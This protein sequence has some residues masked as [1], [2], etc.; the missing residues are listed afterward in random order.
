MTS[1][2]SVDLRMGTVELALRFVHI[3]RS[4]NLKSYK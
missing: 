4:D 2:F 1:E 3:G